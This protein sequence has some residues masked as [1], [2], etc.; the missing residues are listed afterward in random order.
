[1]PK[2]NC[3]FVCRDYPQGLELLTR[4]DRTFLVLNGIQTQSAA[5]YNLLGEAAAL[6][7]MRVNVLRVSPQPQGTAAILSLFRCWADGSLAPD[8]ASDLAE[9]AAPGPYCNGFWHGRPGMELAPAA[10]PEP[11]REPV[12]ETR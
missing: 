12:R 2:D 8:E 9:A 1:V 7:S 10:R 5:I 4:E 3:G 6:R 11:R